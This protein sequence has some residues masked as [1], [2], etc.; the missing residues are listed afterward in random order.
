M[1]DGILKNLK[2]PIQ[3]FRQSDI[4]MFRQSQ[5][6]T[7]WLSFRLKISK[8]ENLSKNS[9]NFKTLFTPMAESSP[10]WTPDAL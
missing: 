6:L 1:G 10:P 4:Q 9:I 5:S 3:I 7:I 8:S 2:T